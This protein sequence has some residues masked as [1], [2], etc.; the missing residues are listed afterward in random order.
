MPEIKVDP[1][2]EWILSKRSFGV[3]RQG[4]AQASFGDKT[5]ALHRIVWALANKCKYSEV[6]WLDHIN[7]DRLDNRIANLRP[8]SPC[9]NAHNRNRNSGIVVK[10]REG[11]YEASVTFRRKNRYIGSFTD[12]AQARAACLAVKVVLCIIESALCA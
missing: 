10:R 3:G 11:R 12:E 7:R 4:Y 6:P 9:L 1:Q 2:F 5:K 8:A